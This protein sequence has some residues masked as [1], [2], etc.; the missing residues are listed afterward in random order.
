MTIAVDWD[1]KHQA[2]KKNAACL[3]IFHDFLS[4]ADVFQNQCFQKILSGTLSEC[5]MVFDPDQALCSKCRA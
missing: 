3:V 2:K 5:Q 1:V 4:S